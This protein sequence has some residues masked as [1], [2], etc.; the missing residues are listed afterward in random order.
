MAEKDEKTIE[1]DEAALKDIGTQVAE[2][3]DLDTK[4]TEAATKAA[5]AAAEAVIAKFDEAVSKKNINDADDANKTELLNKKEM[6]F[7]EAVHKQLAKRY[8]G[9]S[10]VSLVKEFPLLT[11][12][13]LAKMSKERRFYKGIK[14]LI[15]QDNE[16]VK[17]INAFAGELYAF[18]AFEDGKF[19]DMAAKAGYANDAVSA[20]GGAL[21]PDPEFNTTVYENLPKYGII[22]QDG[23]V[24]NTDRTAVY[25]LSLT[26]TVAFTNVA[27]AGA[28]S[29]TKLAFS[30]Q[31]TNLIKYA[32]IIPAT[33]ELS[34]DSIVDYWNL[35][36]NEISRAYG[37]VADT[38]VFTD[39]TNGIVHRPGI[40]VSPLIS[41]GAGTTVA[42][43]DLLKAEGLMEDQLDTSDF[44]FYMRKETFF[45]LAQIKSSSGGYLADSMMAGWNP[46][47]NSPSTPWGTPVHFCRI[48]PRSA[49]VGTTNTAF[50]VYG[51]LKNTNFYNKNGMALTMLQEATITDAQGGSFNLA[52]QDGLAMRAVVRILHL[53]PAGNASKFVAIGTGTVS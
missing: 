49:D 39:S 40:I 38:Q 12:S 21:V 37:L 5:T 14:A 16:T 42:W 41:G 11:Q 45:R 26:G 22:F 1:L 35:V 9:D 3:L 10:D 48:L 53:L 23:N 15:Q 24:Q 4:I 19:E 46:N 30:R 33:N 13:P 29:G 25:A 18:K 7:G 6:P 34:E 51:S 47:P 28:I 52:T 20:D 31:Q 2:S 36:T 44:V 32:A 17:E 50:I 8:M 43:D 27:E